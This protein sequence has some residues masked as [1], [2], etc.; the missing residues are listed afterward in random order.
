VRKGV[1]NFFGNLGD[2]WSAVNSVLQLKPMAAAQNGV[3]FAMNTVF[4]LAGTIDLATDAGIERQKEDFGTTLAHWGVPAGPYLVLPLLGPTTLRDAAALP[5]DF[6]G[7]PLA[8]VTPVATRNAIGAVGVVDTRGRLL[9]LD[10]AADQAIDGYMFRRDVYLQHRQA[11]VDRGTGA[12]G[13]TAAGAITSTEAEAG[14]VATGQRAT[15][16]QTNEQAN[17]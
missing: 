11:Q 10:A 3:R 6:A 4:G 8:Q 15:E 9:P 2:A 14:P 17:P 5:V 13:E 7:H 16:G 12:E 1:S